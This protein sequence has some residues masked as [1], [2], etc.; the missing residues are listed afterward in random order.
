[1]SSDR[2]RFV[3]TVDD[4][5]LWQP[6]EVEERCVRFFEE[7]GV[8]ASFF[9]VPETG[10][11]RPITD[12]P[13]WVLRARSYEAHGFDFQL[14]GYRHEGF[15][16]GAP[17]PWMVRICGDWAC[18]A[19]AESFTGM[20]HLWTREALRD[21]L[22]RA[23]AEFVR[24]FGRTPEVFRAGCLAAGED[25]FRVMGELGLR[26]DSDKIVSPRAWD[27]IAGDFQSTRPWDPR[28]PP[29]PYRLNDSV[30]ELPGI[31]EYAWTP[32][33][34]N[35]EAYSALAMEDMARV[36]ARGG[37]FVLMCHVQRVGDP[38]DDL[39]RQVLA[40]VLER[41]RREHNA[42]FITL[43]E[44]VRLVDTGAVGVARCPAPAALQ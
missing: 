43:R 14:H 20:R 13:E 5:A 4:A 40:A 2:L 37:V 36:S 29:V 26:F 34:E 18:Q 3:I 42:Q 24:A 22:E 9:V 11:G 21:K 33:P 19:E 39:P 6:R 7:E 10:E 27:L 12:D 30:V 25:A 16:F 15:E 41:A 17:E 44:L 8:P 1:M 28:V 38:D 32:T 35:R 31:G 23:M